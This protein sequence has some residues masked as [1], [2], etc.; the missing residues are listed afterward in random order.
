[1]TYLEVL[2]TVFTGC[3]VDPGTAPA[4]PSW[5]LLHWR[6]VGTHRTPLSPGVSWVH[7]W[8]WAATEMC[9]DLR[10]NEWM[11]LVFTHVEPDAQYVCVSTYV[12]V[13]VLKSREKEREREIYVCF[14]VDVDT[15]I[16]TPFEVYE[17]VHL[18]LHGFVHKSCTPTALGSLL[19][20]VFFGWVKGYHH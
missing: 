15:S 2:P 17:S 1:M 19:I 6:C 8:P 13:C 11:R 4:G 9:E 16:P 18:H 3:A 10:A 5:L 20:V 12:Y 7:E 14:L